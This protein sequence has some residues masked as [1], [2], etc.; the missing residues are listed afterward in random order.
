MCQW[1][2]SMKLFDIFKRK[3]K[4]PAYSKYGPQIVKDL[5]KCEWE[6]KVLSNG[7]GSYTS[8]YRNY[9]KG[10]TLVCYSKRVSVQEI[11]VLT[12]DDEAIIIEAIKERDA[13]IRQ[14]IADKII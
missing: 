12:K 5:E 14:K 6:E 11:D 13:R 4:E 1:R 8:F 2:L 3:K 7:L 9:S 10:Y